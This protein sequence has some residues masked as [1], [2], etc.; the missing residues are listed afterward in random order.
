MDRIFQLKKVDDFP[1]RD[2]W[3]VDMFLDLH[4]DWFVRSNNALF[5]K[6]EESRETLL[7]YV[8]N[9]PSMKPLP[10]TMAYV[11]TKFVSEWLI[12]FNEIKNHDQ[13]ER[14]EKPAS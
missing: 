12:Y 2:T 7:D 9:G 3:I 11:I 10:Y 1:I 13:A 14:I 4:K 6:Q 5:S 8:R